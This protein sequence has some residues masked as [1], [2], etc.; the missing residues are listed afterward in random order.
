MCASKSEFDRSGRVERASTRTSLLLE[1]A[2]TGQRETEKQTERDG[3]G[4]RYKRKKG[5]VKSC[6][7]QCAR[8]RNSLIISPLECRLYCIESISISRALYQ[9]AGPAKQCKAEDVSVGHT[10]KHENLFRSV[11]V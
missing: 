4:Q 6:Y 11:L 1:G 3:D 7:S 9:A 2:A 10:S 5:Q 8:W